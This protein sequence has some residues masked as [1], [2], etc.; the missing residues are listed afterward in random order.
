MYIRYLGHSTFKLSG[1]NGTLVTDPYD[2]DMVGLEMGSVSADIITVSHD[3]EDHN[4]VEIVDDT[5]RRDEP[6][7][8]REPGEY[9]VEGI[10]VFGFPSFHDDKKGEERGE[11]TIFVIQIDGIRVVH[12][13]DLGHELDKNLIEQLDGVDVLLLPVGGVY[14]IGPN[15]ALKVMES[16]N[17]SIAIPMHYKTGK[18]K[19]KTFDELK[20]LD[21]F[22]KVYEGEVKRKKEKLAV[23]RVSL[24][25]DA[26]ELVVFE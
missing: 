8:V 9:E 4:N 21:E 25:E 1:K 16:L 23:S 11:N 26:T 24:S 5:A 19:G 10:S 20:T 2:E 13:G 12:L 15:E 14:T 17:P 3:H 22:L 18:H 7:V 6:F